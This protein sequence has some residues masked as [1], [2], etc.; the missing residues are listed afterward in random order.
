MVA[1]PRPPGGQAWLLPHRPVVEPPTPAAYHHKL[2]MIT[3]R[4]AS[5]RSRY[6]VSVRDSGVPS[7]GSAWSG[8]TIMK[9]A[10]AM[11]TCMIASRGRA[12]V[13]DANG[14][15]EIGARRQ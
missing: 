1:G 5:C 3:F 8:S 12:Q 6:R 11:C 14:R 13:G 2:E 9:T 4:R 7:P 10:P 15:V